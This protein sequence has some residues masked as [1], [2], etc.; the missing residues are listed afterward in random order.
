MELSD[1]SIERLSELNKEG[2]DSFVENNSING[3]FLQTWRF[4]DYH[5]KDRFEDYS[6]LLYYKKRIVAVCPG[7][8]TWENGCKTFYSHAGTSYGGPIVS[9]ELYT[10]ERMLVIIEAIE[11]YLKE[12]EFA[13][14]ILKPTMR[15]LS[16]EN[17]ELLTFALSYRG[18]TEYKDLNLYIDY[19]LIDDTGI[20]G[21]IATNRK[22]VIRKCIQ[23][24]CE[25]RKLSSREELMAFHDI[26][27]ENLKKYDKKP[28][29]TVEEWLDIME[30][31]LSENEMEF[32]GIFYNDQM[33]AG[34]LCFLFNRY[35]C[36]HVQNLAA[37]QDYNKLS[38]MSYLYHELMDRYYR[39]GYKNLSWGI[40]TEHMGENLNLGLTFT[41]E[42]FGSKHCLV[43]TFEK[44]LQ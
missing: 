35:E 11:S 28:V 4:L 44:E 6:F 43:R 1:I 34:S 10:A 19:S 39:M 26:L 36:V 5:P 30:N 18:F 37:Y 27:A 7:C 29:H 24:G 9:R 25:I 21:I 8:I 16:L 15:L 38:P 31:R 20:D 33:V 22:Q 14:I 32:H 41:K 23:Q 2:W 40:T 3:T 12:N 13:K 42:S 17:D